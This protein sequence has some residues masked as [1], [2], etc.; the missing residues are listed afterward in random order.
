MIDSLG[1]YRAVAKALGTL[2]ERLPEA[3]ER[4]R[5]VRGGNGGSVGLGHV[6]L[7]PQLIE[8]ARAGKRDEAIAMF[9]RHAQ[10]AKWIFRPSLHESLSASVRRG[11]AEELEDLHCED[12]GRSLHLYLMLNDQRRHMSDWLEH[13]DLHRLE[14]QL[15]FY[16]AE[17]LALILSTPVDMYL[18]HRFYTDW[19]NCFPPSVTAVPWQTYPG[20]VPCPVEFEN[21]ELGYQFGGTFSR[22]WQALHKQA[23]LR[24]AD[25]MIRAREFPRPIIDRKI[26]RL[27]TWAYRLGLR[28][29]S[30]VIEASHA[31]YKYWVEC[32][33][34]Y[35]TPRP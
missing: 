17:F 27:A 32:H 31:Y 13:L 25:E 2:A 6:Y 23:L 33:G 7:S 19:L 5:V 15:P 35:V 16:D 14:M 10:L 11:I 21:K 1:I 34:D 20:H 4:P 9:L 26:L 8:A 28:D 3:P 18:G 30:Y 22:E 29:Y 24:E 12:A